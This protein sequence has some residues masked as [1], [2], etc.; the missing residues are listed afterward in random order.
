M[1]NSV[2]TLIEDNVVVYKRYFDVPVEL[3]FEV[4][5]SPEH[6]SHWWGPDGFTLTTLRMDFNVGGFWEFVM[7]GPDG[8]DYKNKVQF[9]EINAPFLLRY[10]HMGN[11]EGHEDVSFEANIAFE[12][13]GEGASLTFKQIFASKA[14]LER[15]NEKYGAIEGAKQHIGNFAK[16]LET[17]LHA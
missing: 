11:G 8:H 16:Y 3:A 5:T 6:L 1:T 13:S 10:R 12:R 4:W 2:E 17:L 9:V 15:V 14:E 7:H